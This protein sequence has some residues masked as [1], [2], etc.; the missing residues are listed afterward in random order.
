MTTWYKPIIHTP[1]CFQ[2]A[3]LSSK[4]TNFATNLQPFVANFAV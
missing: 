1:L 3:V 4:L 2:K